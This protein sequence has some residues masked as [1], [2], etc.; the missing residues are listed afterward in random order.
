MS[1]RVVEGPDEGLEMAF[2]HDVV[3]MGSN[4]ENHF[5]LTDPTVSR[6]H[7]EITRLREGMLLRDLSST[8]GTV[9]GEVQVKEVFLGENRRFYLG[10]TCLEYR[11]LDEAVDVVPVEESRFEELVGAALPMREVYSVLDRVARTDLTVLIAGETGTGKDLASKAIHKRSAR[12]QCPFVVFDCAAVAHG[13]IETELFGHERGAYTGAVGS[14]PGV[15]EQAHR[16]TIFLDEIGELPLDLQ[17]ALLRVLEQREVRRV[18]DR[19]MRRIDVRV[20]AAS[21]RDLLQCVSDGTF[22]EDLYYR[23]AVVEVTMPPLRERCSDL[24][25]L[26]RHLLQTAGFDHTVRGLAP[27]VVEI[28]EAHPWPGNVRELRNILLRAIPF[29][30]GDLIDLAALPSAL[31]VGRRELTP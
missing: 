14:R 28:F 6:R 10:K 27:E 18:G 5:V 8:N 24:A 7:A 16:G 25:L 21:N 22:R 19:R 12:A 23:L 30:D 15:F 17:P 26:V 29:C 4:A 9:V 2:D 11:L 3:R 1:L 20:V 31:T 13:L